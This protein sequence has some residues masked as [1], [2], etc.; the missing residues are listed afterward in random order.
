MAAVELYDIATTSDN[1]MEKV[2]GIGGFF[3]KS[4]NPDQLNQWYEENLGLKQS[5][6]D[7][8]SGGWWT[9]AV[10]SIF[11]AEPEESDF[12]GTNQCWYINF[13]VNDL[14]AMM[15]Q[16]RE[17]GIEVKLKHGASKFGKFAHLYDPEG[18]LIEIWEP[19]PEL[20]SCRPKE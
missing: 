5:P 13:T 2:T 11:Y 19:S 14:E 7:Q 8:L 1:H 6:P 17:N 20:L 12:A 18:N 4:K 10:P 15:K 3:F 9:N 16:L